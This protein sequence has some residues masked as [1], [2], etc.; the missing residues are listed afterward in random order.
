MANRQTL[1]KS[2]LKAFAQWLVYDGWK[3]EEPKGEYEVLRATKKNKKKP[4]LIYKTL[5]DNFEHY[6]YADEFNGIV[7]QFVKDVK[8]DQC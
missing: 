1:H 4:L 8:S 3:I 5:K 7:K 2:R 6:T